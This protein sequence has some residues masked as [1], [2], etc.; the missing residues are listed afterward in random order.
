MKTTIEVS[1]E[2]NAAFVEV[3]RKIA[4]GEPPI[5][6]LIGLNHFG[7]PEDG[8]ELK[9]G[10]FKPVVEQMQQAATTLLRWLPIYQHLPFGI[11]CPDDVTVVLDALPRIIK[12]LE[13][14]N[15]RRTGRNRIITREICAAVVVEAWRMIHGKAGP[16]SEG[17]QE[18]CKEYWRACGGE[19]IGETDDIEN[20]RR[21]LELAI[22]HDHAWVRS[23]LE[24]VQNSL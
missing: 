5:W 9:P 24:A 11:Q 8:R 2:Y 6:L 18:A 12:D 10:E 7:T 3:A 20:W 15:R 22:A 21:P 14:L 13:R 19:E 23:V 16:R 4:R 1:H 17:V